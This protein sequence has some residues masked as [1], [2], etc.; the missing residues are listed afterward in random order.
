ML[1]THIATAPGSPVTPS[2]D[3]AANATSQFSQLIKMFIE[4]SIH[5]KNTVSTN[6]D[7]TF[8]TGQVYINS[9][10]NNTN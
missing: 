1:H 9:I 6:H 3:F 5:Q 4:L 2:P 8:E 7:Y 10:F